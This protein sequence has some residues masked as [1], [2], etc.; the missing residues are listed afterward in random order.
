M[1]LLKLEYKKKSYSEINTKSILDCLKTSIKIDLNNQLKLV[2]HEL[3]LKIKSIRKKN[4]SNNS[5]HNFNT[6]LTSILNEKNSKDNDIKN[7]I[8]DN[9]SECKNINI[10][11]LPQ[12]LYINRVGCILRYKKR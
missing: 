6:M 12:D 8:N 4:S 11:N 9:N 7:K 2:H 5:E 3:K 10:N 1:Q